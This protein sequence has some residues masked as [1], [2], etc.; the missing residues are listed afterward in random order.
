MRTRLNLI[1]LACVLFV[2][3][4]CGQKTQKEPTHMHDHAAHQ[5]ATTNVEK[6][7]IAF[8]SEEYDFGVVDEGD[9]V[10]HVFVFKNTGESPLIIEK[11]MPSCGCTVPDWSKEPIAPGSNGEI[12]VKFDTNNKPNKQ[13]KTVTIYANTDPAE[14]NLKIKGT[15]T[16]KDV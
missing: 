15:V 2:L 12:K 16:P 13:M 3:G 14:I 7:K 8:D 6:A 4:S 10:E 11:A 9:I 1:P 5:A